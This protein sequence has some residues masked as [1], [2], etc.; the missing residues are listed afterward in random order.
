MKIIVVYDSVFGNTG[1]IAR[2]IGGALDSGNEVDVFNVTR[3]MPENLKGTKLLIVGSPTRSFR[4]TEAI[5]KFIKNL[6]PGALTKVKVAAFD[7][8]ISP[9]ELKS[10]IARFLVKK[11]GYAAKPIAKKLVAK[12]G[13]LVLPPEGFFV[14]DEKG[15]LKQGETERAEGW[16]KELL[17]TALP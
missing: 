8:R 13:I 15:P 4:P 5:S 1:Q 12:G 6:S 2:A 16:A 17:K 7:T 11:G 14:T 3:F 10:A 9:E